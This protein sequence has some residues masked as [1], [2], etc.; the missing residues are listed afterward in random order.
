MG[1]TR[2]T[3][4]VT[5]GTGPVDAERIITPVRDLGYLS[6]LG[7]VPDDDGHLGYVHAAHLHDVSLG[8]SEVLV[9]I[10]P[11]YSHGLINEVAGYLIAHARTIPQAP[12]AFIVEI[13]LDRLRNPPA[14]IAAA[15]ASGET[16]YPGF[17]T[18]RLDGLNAGMPAPDA[19][20]PVL[21]REIAQW[22]FCAAV[23]ALDEHLGNG[24]RH[25]NNLIRLKRGS[26]AVIDHGK[27]CAIPG[28]VDWTVESL[29]PHHDYGNRLFQELRRSGQPLDD[30]ASAAMDCASLHPKAFAQIAPE[31]NYWCERLLS[32]EEH[33][34]FL[35]FLQQR[36]LRLQELLT[37]RFRL[38]C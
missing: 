2:T 31:L 16:T 9:K 3:R 24:D 36:G 5:D 8:H 26:F 35:A 1:G 37:K 20:L 21:H 22:S 11:S 15:R 30:V 19:D 4:H 14:W 27:L 7:A 25:P 12:N 29:M 33:D 38:L 34:A 13:P 18:I 32:R 6:F 28:T 23:I 10:F 17:A